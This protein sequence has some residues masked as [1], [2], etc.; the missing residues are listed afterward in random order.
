MTDIKLTDLSLANNVSASDRV[1]GVVDGVSRAIPAEFFIGQKGDP[2]PAVELRGTETHVQWR[3]E[4]EDDWTDL[5]AISDL[6][7]P[8]G[9]KGDQ[10]DPGPGLEF[11]ID[12][13]RVGVRVEGDAEFVYTDP[14]TGPAGADANWEAITQSAYDA[15]DPPDPNTLYVIVEE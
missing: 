9:E 7:G 6:D 3:V 11:D 4:G 10:G 14:L 5:V 2:G 8:Q 15:L 13:D 12:A 1:Y